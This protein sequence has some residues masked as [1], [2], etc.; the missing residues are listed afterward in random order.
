MEWEEDWGTPYFLM[1]LYDSANYNAFTMHRLS[2]HSDSE[3]IICPPKSAP[4][5]A[6]K[7]QVLVFALLRQLL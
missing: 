7:P 4:S 1:K 2:Y 3:A 5:L 6:F